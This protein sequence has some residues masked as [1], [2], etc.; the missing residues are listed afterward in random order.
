MTSKQDPEKPVQWPWEGCT[1]TSHGETVFSEQTLLSSLVL[2]T[3]QLI[4]PDRG[5]CCCMTPLWNRTHTSGNPA[6]LTTQQHRYGIH[7]PSNQQ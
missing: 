4:S 3:T 6:S 1:D 2:A 7:F 5:H